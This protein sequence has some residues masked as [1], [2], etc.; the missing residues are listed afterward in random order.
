[1]KLGAIFG[2]SVRHSFYGDGV[3]SDFAVEPT[4]DTVLLLKNYRC[5]LKPRN[6]GFLTVTELGVDGLPLIAVDTTAKFR[7]NLRLKNADFAL[8][9]DL[10]AI[11]QQAVPWFTATSTVIAKGGSLALTTQVD[12][13]ENGVFA[14]VEIPASV[15]TSQDN[16][17]LE[18]VVDF[19]PK[20]A[21][22]MYYCITDLKLTGKDLQLVDIG[23]PGPPLLFSTAN[24]TD[25]T[26]SPD[27]SDARAI[28]LAS[29]F[30]DL[31]RVRF[32]SDDVVPCQQSPRTLS[33]QLDGHNF[34]DVLPTPLLRNCAL[35]PATAQGNQP[36]QDALFQ[37][38]K[39]VSY[40]FSRNGV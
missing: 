2:L 39:Y 1:V 30:P 36:Q 20:R 13:L 37:V 18:F 27:M 24:R 17:P 11:N 19:Q 29:R 25:L 9:T 34:P 35:W 23:T 14:A 7:F 15:F 31:A 6:N 16:W 38:V 4:S 5:V 26:Q 3:C 10:S 21:R 32:V 28:E 40:S 12:P 8:F 33:L 22:W